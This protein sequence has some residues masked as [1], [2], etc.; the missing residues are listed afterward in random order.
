MPSPK[1]VI[2]RR[3]LIFGALFGLLT[4]NWPGLGRAFCG[5]YAA[6]T[7]LAFAPVFG[8]TVTFDASKPGDR[9]DEWDLLVRLQPP[10]GS[11]N[12]HG[13][14]VQ[15]RRICYMPLALFVAFAISCPP[16]TRRG[17]WLGW[18]ACLAL[19]AALQG[20]AMLSVF[21]TRGVL[22]LDTFLNLAVDLAS[23]AL[24]AAPVMSFALPPLLWMLLAR[25]F[26]VLA[27]LLRNTAPEAQ[28]A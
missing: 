14:R 24:I 16:R 10:P 19:F 23:R 12:V 17:Y 8:D 27:V 13:V 1:W 18:G 26:N 2:I 21:T 15:I 9:F 28:R 6:V 5:A 20:L 7:A 3:L 25:P 22:N 11:N 4:W